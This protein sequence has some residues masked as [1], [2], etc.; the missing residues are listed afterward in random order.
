MPN[1]HNFFK[2]KSYR[3]GICLASCITILRHYFAKTYQKID[4]FMNSSMQMSLWVGLHKILD[5]GS[6]KGRKASMLQ[7]CRH[8]NSC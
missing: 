5:L 6:G 8:G 7:K 3:W 4:L 1:V 2:N